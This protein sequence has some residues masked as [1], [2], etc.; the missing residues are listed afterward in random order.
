MERFEYGGEYGGG[1]HSGTWWALVVASVVIVCAGIGVAIYFIIKHSKHGAVSP[2]ASGADCHNHGT[3]KQGVCACDHGYSGS[4]C[5]SAASLFACNGTSCEPC[6]AGAPDCTLTSSNCNGICN[7]THHITANM[8]YKCGGVSGTACTQ[9]DPESDTSGACANK[10]DPTCGGVCTP[11]SGSLIFKCGGPEGT[12]CE[13]CT[14]EDVAS[15]LDDCKYHTTCGTAC[16]SGK[17]PNTRPT[18]KCSGTTCAPCAAGS[19]DAACVYTST[20]CDSACDPTPPPSSATQVNIT[21]SSLLTTDSSTGRTP[22][23]PSKV[24]HS[25]YH[26]D[27]PVATAADLAKPVV[28]TA[29]MKNAAYSEAPTTG[30]LTGGVVLSNTWTN[31]AITGDQATSRA[32]RVF[33][34]QPAGTQA[35]LSFLLDQKGTCWSAFMAKVTASPYVNYALTP[36]EPGVAP[37]HDLSTLN[38]AAAANGGA[39]GYSMTLAQALWANQPDQSTAGA[40]SCSFGQFTPLSDVTNPAAGAWLNGYV[41]GGGGLTW[42]ASQGLNG[43]FGSFSGAGMNP[44]G[45]SPNLGKGK[46]VTLNANSVNT[47]NSF[48][49]VDPVTGTPALCLDQWAS[50]HTD[51]HGDTSWVVTKQGGIVTSRKYAS[52]RYEVVARVDDRPGLIWAIWTF[53]AQ[54]KSGPAM[55]GCN[56]LDTTCAN[57][58]KAPSTCD[59]CTMCGGSDKWCRNCTNTT[60]QAVSQCQT[61]GKAGP[62]KVVAAAAAAAETSDAAFAGAGVTAGAHH[63]GD[64]TAAVAAAPAGHE[65]PDT[66]LCLSSSKVSNSTALSTDPMYLTTA[67]CAQCTALGGMPSSQYLNHEIDIEIPSNAPQVLGANDGATAGGIARGAAQKAQG[68]FTSNTLNINSYRWTNSGGTGS[69]ENL[70]VSRGNMSQGVTRPAKEHRFIGDGKYHSYAFEWHT[71]GPDQTPII[72]FFFDGDYMGSCD[73]FVPSLASRL[74]I[75]QWISSKPNWAGPI[76]QD[77]CDARFTAGTAAGAA[78]ADKNA[79]GMALTSGGT[80]TAPATVLYA[81][82]YVRSVTITP[83]GEA[84]DVHFNDA[85]DQPNHI[86]QYSKFV[87][88][89]RLVSDATDLTPAKTGNVAAWGTPSVSPTYGRCLPYK[90][91]KF[92][93][94]PGSYKGTPSYRYLGECSDGTTPPV[95]QNMVPFYA[96]AVPFDASAPMNPGMLGFMGTCQSLSTAMDLPASFDPED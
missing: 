72:N 67:D 23:P 7:P 92:P 8:Y 11:A 54:W 59:T 21:V 69:Y 4:R 84:N 68:G 31:T 17:P 26:E 45:W 58:D 81:R 24:A 63:L 15:G 36:P 60:C 28:F 90:Y 64:V 16:A 77:L 87:S 37:A 74:W 85:Q 86:A 51:S 71:G 20:T 66:A 41:P 47:T 14:A 49:G 48:V 42:D 52:G 40:S 13:L 29:A 57:G 94:A 55:T 44:K 25:W 32:Y 91:K 39:G 62:C 93:T 30:T 3:C 19:A 12:T 73:A 6:V 89:C 56:L 43:E 2:C 18:F 88:C 34:G 33:V 22:I 65:G 70:W 5:E 61:G 10:N 80:T 95:P 76:D 35:A 9:C 75:G 78:T 38:H 96:Q 27:N 50:K 46:T 82:T 1:G 53:R 79:V 83:Y